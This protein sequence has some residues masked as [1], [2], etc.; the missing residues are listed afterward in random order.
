MEKKL[1]KKD[2]ILI[3]PSMSVPIPPGGQP[4]E[5]DIPIE[6][7]D[8]SDDK[9][10]KEGQEGK[11]GK[12]GKG[13]KSYPSLSKEKIKEIQDKLKKA[14]EDSKDNSQQIPDKDLIGGIGEVLN[15]EMSKKYQENAGI[16]VKLPDKQTQ[17]KNNDELLKDIYYHPDKYDIPQHG[18]GWGTI[19][20]MGYSKFKPVFNWTNE[21]KNMIKKVTEGDKKT[22]KVSREKSNIGK[23]VP[24]EEITS[25]TEL[26]GIFVAIDTSGSVDDVDFNIMITELYDIVMK[27]PIRQLR[28]IY[29]SEGVENDIFLKG[30][31]P[32]KNFYKNRTT[33]KRSN[34]GTNYVPPMKYMLDPNN[35]KLNQYDAFIFFTDAD[36]T[37]MEELIKSGIKPPSRIQDK[38]IWI[39]TRDDSNIQIVPWGKKLT[40]TT[41]QIA[42]IV[43]QYNREHQ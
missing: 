13:G 20:E 15:P 16:D 19:Y 7:I 40:L 29:F 39:I 38:F 9:E 36:T 3:M 23:P 34:G 2:V 42:D 41:K 21:L 6:T 5:S 8:P 18:R 25:G 35:V 32:I 22:Y 10:E 17:S 1:T 31:G 26:N 14:I 27:F 24:F 43:E 12:E 11:E 28:I 37:A 33:I 30:R 4:I